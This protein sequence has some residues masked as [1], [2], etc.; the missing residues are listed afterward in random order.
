MKAYF[1]LSRMPH[2]I[3][4]IAAPAFC[5]LLWLGAFPEI[6]VLLVALITVFSGY[7]AVYA[8]N[9][10]IGF[11]LDQEKISD[12]SSYKAY[13]V[14]STELRH[15]IA[16]GKLSMGS[17]MIWTSFWILV[18]VVGAYWLNPF[19]VVIL[20]I[21]AICE[22][23]Y[24]VLFK[25]SCWRVI[26]SGIV[27][28]AGPIAAIF[29]VDPQPVLSHIMLV[30]L[31]VSLWEIGGQNIPADWHDI[32]EDR[33]VKACT[34][35]LI[36]DKHITAMLVLAATILTVLLSNFLTWVSPMHLGWIYK[37]GNTLIGYFLLI[38]PAYHLYR[39]TEN[40]MPV[41]LFNR[42]SYYPLALLIWLLIFFA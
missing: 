18:A 37:V 35:P 2:A 31:W 7:T 8:L 4:D 17:A 25:I 12:T 33:K 38:M 36:F 30:L 26:F 42:A 40:W 20:A 21:A 9:D 11:K 1:A 15:P 39:G 6:K 29:V 13:A 34:I 28:A 14:E 5:A 32:D 22:V 10:L 41:H 19:T 16:Q 3:L 24:C 27:K 23:I